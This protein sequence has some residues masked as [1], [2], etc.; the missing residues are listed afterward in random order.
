M[1]CKPLEVD[2]ISGDEMQN[3]YQR[4]QSIMQGFKSKTIAFNTTVI[5]HWI[6]DTDYFWYARER[7]EGKEF[8]LVDAASASNKIAFDHQRLADALMEVSGQCVDPD[9][10]P[11]KNL[12]W[13]LSPLN[14]S[15]DALDKRWQ[16]F[17]EEGLCIELPVNPENWLISPNGKQAAFAREYNIWIID[18]ASGDE[19]PLT[20][21]GEKLYP[22]AVGPSAWGYRKAGPTEAVWSPDSNY[23]L[24]LQADSRSVKTLPIMEYVP[25]DNT[26]RPRVM[27][28]R[29][30]AFPGDENVEQYRF[31]SIEVATG[32]H[33]EAHYQKVSVFR[34]A[35]GFF[36]SGH[37]WWSEDNRHAYFIEIVRGGD[38]TVRF[39]EFDTHTGA[40][41][42]L[43]EEQS[44]ETFFKLRLDSRR[45]IHARALA[46]SD[47]M[48]WFSERSGWGHLYLYNIKTGELKNQITSGDWVLRDIHHYDPV[49]RE[50]IIQTSGRTANQHHYYRDICRVNIDSG[51]LTPI[52]ATDDEYVVFDENNELAVNVKAIGD[53][54]HSYGV[55]PTGNYLVATRSRA[56]TVPV[57]ILLD[58]DGRECLVL[59]TADVSGLPEGWQWPEPVKL[60]GNDG[61]TDI[62]GVVYRPSHFSPDKSYPILDYSRA[63]REGGYLAAGSFTNNSI[64]GLNYFNPA[65]LAELGFIVVDICGRG[66]M[67]RS[68][69]FSKAVHI[70]SP[71]S[72][73]L[74]DQ[75]A[76]I[77]QLAKR[78][79]YMDINRVGAGGRVSSSTAISG[80]LGYPDF[81]RV[82]VSIG[83]LFDLRLS[84]AFF[85]E[86]YGDMPGTS[87]TLVSSQQFAHHLKG[88]LL[89]MHGVTAPSVT[90][91]QAFS[92]IDALQKAN[93]DFDMLLLPNTAYGGSGYMVRR[94]WDYLVRHLLGA[95]PPL[96]FNLSSPAE[97]LAIR[98]AK[99]VTGN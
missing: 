44:P 21:D 93:K 71:A 67:N 28:D 29:R 95:E 4:A 89:I 7:Q 3:R 40:T 38:H 55:S 82:G 12:A 26:L 17:E 42:I 90:V 84:S 63:T 75:V 13:I 96:R 52:I 56:D 24:T 34:N 19:R 35:N 2:A 43:I 16:F 83:G 6:D 32:K 81:Y 30:V 91:A 8:R 22:Y 48:L 92:L 60:L 10:L 39:V 46:G 61:K 31:L 37:G 25:K 74:A 54:H 11:I 85:G 1:S 14:I 73:S 98:K 59:E 20:R 68:R 97:A 65:G 51:D 72:D 5:P 27:G 69:N 36:S 79:P 66:T 99:T 80:L 50:L 94:G 41:H 77:R 78:Y 23:L 76:G 49:R 88:K 18:L 58:R 53:I 64:G 86:A 45:P 70:E 57:S 87:G 9:D 33:Q 15:F 47:D 62:Y